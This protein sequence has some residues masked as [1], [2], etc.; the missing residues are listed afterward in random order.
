MP[1]TVTVWRRSL[2]DPVDHAVRAAT[3][4]MAITKRWLQLLTDP[5]RVVEHRTNDALVRGGSYRLGLLGQLSARGR[6]DNELA[7]LVV[8]AEARRARIT[9]HSEA[10]PHPQ[11]ERVRHRPLSAHGERQCRTGPRSSPRALPDRRRQRGPLL[12]GPCTV[13]VT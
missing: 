2:I 6:S 9:A 11:L 1:T 7:S 10:R 5:T 13:T 4:A 3:C 8:H 12:A